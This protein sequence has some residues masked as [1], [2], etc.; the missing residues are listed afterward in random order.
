VLVF[1]V[2]ALG[3][4][5]G[6]ASALR[7]TAQVRKRIYEMERLDYRKQG[8]MQLVLWPAVI[9]LGITLGAFEK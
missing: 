8:P 3:A 9:T 1:D 5:M 2:I 6:V 7:S 4:T